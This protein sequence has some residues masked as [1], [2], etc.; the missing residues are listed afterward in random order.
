MMRK[1]RQ[2]LLDAHRTSQ[3]AEA[4]FKT[5]LDTAKVEFRPAN[6]AGTAAKNAKNK[7]SDVAT[8]TR[9]AVTSRPGAIVAVGAAIG[10]YLFRKPI[11]SAVRTQ[12]AQR[13]E[14]KRSVR[15]FADAGKS[16]KG[17][18]ADPTPKSTLTEEV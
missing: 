12:I 13:K 17:P 3:D 7:V 1:A 11:A 18:I 2:R 4:R 10:L 8:K 16:G 9:Q 6:M 15:P 14:A 5:T